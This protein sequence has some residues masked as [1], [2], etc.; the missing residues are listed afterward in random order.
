MEEV[1]QTIAES[2]LR[3]WVIEMLTSVPGLP[4]ILQSI[5]ILAV[6]VIVS[7][8]A[9]TQMRYLGLAVW[10]QEPGEMLRRGVPV[11]AW[12]LFVAFA[13]G[14]S[15]VI[16][17]PARYFLNPVAYWKVVFLFT[18]LGLAAALYVRERRNPGVWTATVG[19]RWTTGVLSVL[20]LV[21]WTGVIFAGRWIAYADYLYFE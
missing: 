4:P 7:A 2:E 19:A 5:H 10:V 15:F 20:G 13:S 8:I 17:R 6:A 1:A 12:A 16:A 9:L 14:I 3:V 18:A 21:A 11:A